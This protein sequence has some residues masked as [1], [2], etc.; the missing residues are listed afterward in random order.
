MFSFFRKR[1][2]EDAPEGTPL[3]R[4]VFESLDDL[5]DE[6]IESMFEPVLSR[7]PVELY[8]DTAFY[9]DTGGDWFYRFLPADSM[10]PVKVLAAKVPGFI[11]EYKTLALCVPSD[12][13]GTSLFSWFAAEGVLAR[14]KALRSAVAHNVETCSFASLDI[15]DTDG[16]RT[17]IASSIPDGV[18]TALEDLLDMFFSTGCSVTMFCDRVF[19]LTAFAGSI[20]KPSHGETVACIER[21]GD[22]FTIWNI[23]NLHGNLFPVNSSFALVSDIEPKEDLSKN[24]AYLAS[25]LVRIHKFAPPQKGVFIDSLLPVEVELPR[26]IILQTLRNAAPG[27]SDIL[28]AETPDAALRG[29]AKVV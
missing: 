9:R 12:K 23:V 21:R 11:A 14:D 3:R 26:P 25:E 4:G 15:A 8:W 7:T 6:H 5:V 27:A 29:L 1:N 17:G 24:T 20:A 2:D 13:C 28:I 10:K 19:P 18:R 22:F 16:Y